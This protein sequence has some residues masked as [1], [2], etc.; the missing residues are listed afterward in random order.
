M[1]YEIVKGDQVAAL[2]DPDAGYRLFP[3]PAPTDSRI[4]MTTV[5]LEKIENDPSSN[6][7]RSEIDEKLSCPPKC[8][9]SPQKTGY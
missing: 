1:M 4:S 2:A 5:S 6:I 8:L 7:F 9:P 3:H